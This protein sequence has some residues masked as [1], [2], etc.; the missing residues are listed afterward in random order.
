MKVTEKNREEP[1]FPEFLK[2]LGGKALVERPIHSEFDIISLTNEGIT[3]QSLE[4]LIGYLG[5][6]KKAFSEN[7]LDTSV[8]TIERKKSTDK[9]SKHIT[10]VAIEIAQVVEH[11]MEVFEN[12]EKVKGWFNSPIRALNYQKPIELLS[13]PTGLRMVNDILGRIEYGVYS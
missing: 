10:S 4:A 1:G 9:L 12:E 2:F 5:I 3:K 7:I 13:S 6:S 11:A 8:K